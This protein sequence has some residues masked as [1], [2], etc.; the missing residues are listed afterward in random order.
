[1]RLAFDKPTVIVKDDKTSYS[2]DTAQIEHV[3]YP[4]DLRFK[5]VAEFKEKLAVKLRATHKMSED[6]YF[7]TFLKHFGTFN[8]ARLDTKEVSIQKYVLEELRAMRVDLSNLRANNLQSAPGSPARA[9]PI[10]ND[11]H[12]YSQLASPTT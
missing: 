4:R 1:M 12:I 3:S 9:C 11:M 5:Q 8:V 6:P 2:F 7:S 10:V